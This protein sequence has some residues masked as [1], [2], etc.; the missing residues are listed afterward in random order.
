MLCQESQAEE[1]VRGEGKP[2]RGGG[3]GEGEGKPGGRSEGRR[4]EWA[5]SVTQE[6]TQG[7]HELQE[8]K[9]FM[10]AL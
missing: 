1:G 9:G 8:T 4:Q 3:R 7:L 10:E 2:G 5:P 6:Q